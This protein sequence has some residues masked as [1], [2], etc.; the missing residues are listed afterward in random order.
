MALSSSTI[1]IVNCFCIQK[2][3]VD[4]ELAK[5]PSTATPLTS[6]F[7]YIVRQRINFP[8]VNVGK[9]TPREEGKITYADRL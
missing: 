7:H 2:L 4:E 5:T 6:D 9:K 3:N 8:I 1:R